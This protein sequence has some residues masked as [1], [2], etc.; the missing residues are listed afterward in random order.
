[1]KAA[2]GSML[3]LAYRSICNQVGVVMDKVAEKKWVPFSLPNC[4]FKY[5][6]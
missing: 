1:M 6:K 4:S 2:S 3:A 5:V